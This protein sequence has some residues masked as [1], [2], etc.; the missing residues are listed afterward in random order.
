MFTRFFFILRAGILFKP[1]PYVEISVDGGAAVK[2]DHCKGTAHPKWE[3][4]FPVLV[5][6]YSKILFRV[7]NHHQFMKDDLLGETTLD[8][9]P[10]LEKTSG[11]CEY[12]S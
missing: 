7:F 10:L 12:F 3:E 5:S 4:T 1:D 9:Y 6:P 11:K 2:T 8:L